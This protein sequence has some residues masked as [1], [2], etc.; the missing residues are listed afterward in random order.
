[1]LERAAIASW[2]AYWDRKY[3]WLPTSTRQQRFKRRPEIATN[4]LHDFQAYVLGE[5]ERRC[6]AAGVA[7]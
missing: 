2:S 5:Y 7:P 6:A 3:A 1:V 4:H